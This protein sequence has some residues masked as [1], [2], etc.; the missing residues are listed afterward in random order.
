M[1]VK[2]LTLRPINF[3]LLAKCCQEEDGPYRGKCIGK[4]N[5]YHHQVS[6]AIY[7]VNDWTI[8]ITSFIYDGTGQDTFFWAGASNRPGPQGFIVPDTHGKCVLLNNKLINY[9]LYDVDI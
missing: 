3:F 8:L 1:T 4:L 6:G 7:A 9:I 2:I 5:S